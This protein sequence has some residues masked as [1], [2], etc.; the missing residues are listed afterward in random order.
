MRR[1][2]LPAAALAVSL[3][4]LVGCETKTVEAPTSSAQSPSTQDRATRNIERRAV[5]AVVWGMPAVNY[6]LMYQAM[7]SQAHGD[8]NQIVYW[9]RLP[10]WKNQTLTPNP[11]AIYIMPFFNTK[12]VGAMVLEIPPA[13]GGTIVGSIDDAWQTAI[14]DVGP[15]GVDK[16]KGGKY[17]I[18]PPDFKGK[19]PA[20]YLPMPA[21]TYQ[22]YALL[23]SILKSGSDADVAA[24]VE[25]SK[26]VKVYPLSQAAHPPDTKWSDAIDVVFDSTIP[27]DSTFFQHLNR[28]VQYEPWLTRDKAMIDPLKSL[29][30]EKGKPFNPDASIQQALKEGITEAHAWLESI[31]GTAFKFPLNP[32]YHWALP[33]S[34]DFAK[35]IQNNY[36]DPNSYPTDDRG[37]AYSYAVFSAKHLGAGQ[38]YL[39]TIKD[40]NDQYFSG[41]STYKLSVPANVPVSEYWSATVYNRATHSFIR[42]VDHL[43]PLLAEHRPPEEPRR[44]RRHLLQPQS[45]RRQRLQLDPHQTPTEASKSSSGSTGR[46]SRCSTRSGNCPISRRCSSNIAVSLYPSQTNQ[47]GGHIE[48]CHSEINSPT[49]RIRHPLC[50]HRLLPSTHSSLAITSAEPPASKTA[51]RRLPGLLCHR[52]RPGRADRFHQ[53]TER[54][55]GAQ[56]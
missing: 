10:S 28:M 22:T 19:S 8:F 30:I 3:A 15:A 9:S 42:N 41:A 36:E 20:G 43:G 44:L 5:Q 26:R 33:A 21:S 50:M 38:Y 18:L 11:D 40:K 17:L 1:R 16:G 23:R 13:A 27:Y 55:H 29:S 37:L 54:Q 56:T 31:Y 49:G 7:V 4:S 12:D 2:I 48:H 47:A 25:Y 52:S 34:P 51:L 39:M 46:R 24:A 45:P 14:E 6:D 32:E 35:A 53:G